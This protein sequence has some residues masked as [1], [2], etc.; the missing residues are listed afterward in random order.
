MKL[1]CKIVWTKVKGAFYIILR[2][3]RYLLKPSLWHIINWQTTEAERQVIN[4]IYIKLLPLTAT[5][6]KSSFGNKFMSQRFVF[7]G[8]EPNICGLDVS[9]CALKTNPWA[10]IR[11][12]KS[13]CWKKL[14]APPTCRLNH[15][16][17]FGSFC[18]NITQ[19]FIKSL[20]DK[21]DNVYSKYLFLFGQF[22]AI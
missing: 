7:N 17:L 15:L 16:G 6:K 8:Y 18:K 20:F 10:D 3:W 19:Y 14:L 12:C 2:S 9:Y 1:Y 11:P 5:T 22:D 13:R 21:T 4:W